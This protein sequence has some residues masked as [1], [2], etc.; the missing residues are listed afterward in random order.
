MT[1]FRILLS[2]YVK[3]KVFYI[4]LEIWNDTLAMPYL[5]HTFLTFSFISSLDGLYRLHSGRRSFTPISIA[6]G[7]FVLIF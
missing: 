6:M 7:A 3:S 5:F 2:F 1:S 4:S